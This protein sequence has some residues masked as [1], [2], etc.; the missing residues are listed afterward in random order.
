[1]SD[2]PETVKNEIE[3]M[4]SALEQGK[5]TISK[6]MKSILEEFT[7]EALENFDYYI[8]ME[9]RYRYE[10]WIRQT[11]DEIVSGLLAGDTRWLKNQNIIS[12]YN[13]QKVQKIRLEILKSSGEEIK[14]CFINGLQEE[15]E[16]LKK[17]RDFYRKISHRE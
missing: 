3:I 15:I 17:D 16:Q 14:D 7:N 9:E 4:V 10:R 11:C 8:E 1:M 13:W 2:I 12:E 6:K 5:E